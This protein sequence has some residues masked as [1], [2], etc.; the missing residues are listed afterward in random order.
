MYITAGSRAG[1]KA[2]SWCLYELFLEIDYT[3]R[4]TITIILHTDVNHDKV[5]IKTI[6]KNQIKLT[7]TKDWIRL[8][9]YKSLYKMA[10][11]IHAL[12]TSV[13]S[14]QRR[15]TAS[16][17]WAT[18]AYGVHGPNPLEDSISSLPLYCSIEPTL[19]ATLHRINVIGNLF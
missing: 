7:H 15:N 12:C 5:D 19:Y 4:C 2:R 10:L 11:A 6:P 9:A 14:E 13:C 17:K 1:S 18:F 16:R 8:A 3:L